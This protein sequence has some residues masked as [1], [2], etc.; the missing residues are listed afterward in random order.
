MP[1]WKHITEAYY[2]K[3]LGAVPC[4]VSH[5]DSLA[6][7]PAAVR[8]EHLRGY[9]SPVQLCTYN[10]PSCAGIVSYSPSIDECVIDTIRSECAT[11]EAIHGAFEKVFAKKFHAS[12]KFFLAKT[13]DAAA[14]G[15]K[16]LTPADYPAYET[17]HRTLFP[18]A[19]Q[20]EWL[21]DYYRS[22]MERASIYGIF[23]DGMLVCTTDAPDTPFDDPVVEIGV[24]TL[25][26]YRGHG[27]ATMVSAAAAA[28]IVRQGKTP[29]WSCAYSNEASRR[30]ALHI[31]FNE[32]GVMSSL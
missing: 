12:R 25:P 7:I 2:A 8:D 21:S 15:T 30:I 19:H 6:F 4:I 13:P 32:L 10:S 29:L 18:N 27:F 16:R 1:G 28:G 31:G 5:C 3:L 24:N 23:R 22:M 26:A 20:E 11:L 14:E 9:S 17:F